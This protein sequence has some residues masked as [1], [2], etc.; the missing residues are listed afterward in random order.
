M[1]AWVNFRHIYYMT[2]KPLFFIL[3]ISYLEQWHLKYLH[4][5][6]WFKWK[7]TA[8][9]WFTT[10]GLVFD[11]VNNNS[12]R[13]SQAVESRPPAIFQD[14]CHMWS[15]VC[16][17]RLHFGPYMYKM[18]H[19]LLLDIFL[20]SLNVAMGKSQARNQEQFLRPLSKLIGDFGALFRK[21]ALPNTAW[22]HFQS[23][24]C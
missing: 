3:N 6:L 10:K 8:Q 15:T 1:L 14:K 22:D 13:Q 9:M 18:V 7:S 24:S 5:L 12:G 17:W 23:D 19:N 20:W 16:R 21:S 2:I 11:T 4:N